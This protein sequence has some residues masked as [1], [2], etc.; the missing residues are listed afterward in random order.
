MSDYKFSI[1]AKNVNKIFLKKSQRVDALIDFNIKI[2]KGTIL[3]F[4]VPLY[5]FSVLFDKLCKYHA[6]RRFDAWQHTQLYTEESLK[7]I[8]KRPPNKQMA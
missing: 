2:E 4:S 5:G 6:P 3:Y 7:F 8:Q 1:E